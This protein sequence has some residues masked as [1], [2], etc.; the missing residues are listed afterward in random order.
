MATSRK[1][2]TFIA[3]TPQYEV[4]LAPPWGDNPEPGEWGCDCCVV[5]A[6]TKRE[7]KIIA[8]R[9]MSKQNRNY[10]QDCCAGDHVPY[11][12]IDLEE[13]DLEEYAIQAD[14]HGFGD[15]TLQEEW[16]KDYVEWR[17]E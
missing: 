13:I 9:H 12:H 11:K 5:E 7:A 10:F 3:A 16:G 8:Y 2:R 6:Y 15:I 4:Y 14:L 17:E 1:L